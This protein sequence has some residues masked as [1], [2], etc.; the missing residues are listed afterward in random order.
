MDNKDNKDV[1]DRV[2]AS[3]PYLLPLLD[4]LPFGKFILFN[5]PFVARALSPLAP[6]S[7]L[8]NSFPFLPFIVFLGVY[9][10]IINNFNFSKFVR[11]NAMQAVLLD[12]LLI[13]PQVI[14]S[15]IFKAPSDD[16]GMQAY[17]SAYNTI[18]L[19]VAISVAYGMG[20]SLVGQTARIPLVAEAADSQVRDGPGF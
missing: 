15:D 19:F 12:V 3:L 2:V 7:M 17:I 20:S 1:A 6:L 5:Y 14:L 10:G 13:I 11:Y 18:F 8:Y 4:A 9:S 16:L